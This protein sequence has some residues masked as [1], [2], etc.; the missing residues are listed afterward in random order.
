MRG[1]HENTYHRG[2]PPPNEMVFEPALTAMKRSQNPTFGP[3]SFRDYVSDHDVDANSRTP[4]YISVDKFSDLSS[5]L[6]DE[7]VMVLRV[8]SA[9]DGTG[10]AFLLV[11]APNSV[12]EFFLFDDTIFGGQPTERFDTPTEPEN[13]FSF[14]HLPKLSETSLVNLGL[15]SGVVADAL[16]LDTSGALA[17]PA[18]G[19]STFTFPVKPHSQI[20][21]T[22]THSRG[23]VEI[24]TLFA[25]RRNGELALFVIEAKTGPRSSLAKHKL[26]YPILALSRSLSAEI[27]IIPV[28]LRCRRTNDTITFDVAEC[29]FPDPRERQPAVD[30][31]SVEDTKVKKLALDSRVGLAD[32]N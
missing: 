28:Y 9:P 8:G 22:V 25:E 19:S 29:R 26:V 1:E 12:A 14:Q 3:V 17:P 16:E 13:I 10:T 18:T 30:E 6:R 4:R 15:A 11:N 24:D 23:Q 27:P 32:R 21:E 2:D 31:L 5:E 7:D 20:P